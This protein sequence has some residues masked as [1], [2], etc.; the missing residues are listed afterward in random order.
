MFPHFMI[1]S[2]H[3]FHAL[4]LLVLWFIGI[5][6]CTVKYNQAFR[7]KKRLDKWIWFILWCNLVAFIEWIIYFGMGAVCEVFKIGCSALS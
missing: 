3:P 2:I 4:I 6:W 1:D 5:S 7:A